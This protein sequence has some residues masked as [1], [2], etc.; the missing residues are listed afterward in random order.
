MSVDTTPLS[1]FATAVVGYY[2]LL[3]GIWLVRRARSR[4]APRTTSSKP[5][6]VLVLPCRNEE[7]VL[8]T[9]LDSLLASSY[10]DLLVLVMNDGSTDRTSDV[11]RSYASRGVMVV[12]RVPPHAGKGKG[13]VLNHAYSLIRFWVST[14]HPLLRGRAASDIVVGIMDADGQLEHSALTAVAPY[15][16]D[17][18]VGGVQIGVRIAN[19]TQDV[20]ARMQDLEF[21]GFSAFVQEARDV[22]GSVGLGGNGQF[23]RLTALAS[24]GT[25][26][27]SDRLTEDLD[28]GLTLL[29]KGWRL[30]YC[31]EAFV[32]QQGLT[33]LRPL[34]RQRTRW[35]Q[36]HYQCWSHLPALWR[37]QM[38]LRV[39]LDATVYLGMIVFI[40]MVS[41]G[42]ATSLLAG[43]GLVHVTNTFLNWIPGERE[44][45]VTQLTLSLAPLLV[46]TG[47]YQKHAVRRLPW[48]ELPAWAFLFALYA[49][50][51]MISQV[52]AWARLA[53]SRSAWDKTPRIAA[54]R[55][56][57]LAR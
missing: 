4:P 38:P 55:A 7:A 3:W 12:D 35:V 30:R 6:F 31:S 32:A 10:E 20:L 19:A 27:W 36:G 37:A 9:T 48:W 56:A 40:V 42:A 53:R 24:V 43:L 5:F 2:L 39:R 18:S 54:V 50:V 8:A 52:W 33:R 34:L 11:A 17:P 44:R 13:D 47:V 49:Y 16:D 45:A 14:T 23:T 25:R 28:L 41:V 51:F 21:V 15:F 26:P 46:F 29:E 57:E 1:W 22:V